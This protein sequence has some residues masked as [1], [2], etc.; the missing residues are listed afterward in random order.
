MTRRIAVYLLA[1]CAFGQQFRIT[2]GAIDEQVFQRNAD[3]RA[4]LQ[5]G[6]V[7]PNGSTVEARLL[8]RN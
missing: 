2:S 6:G 7:A 1:A 3:G 5:I 4:N 8:L